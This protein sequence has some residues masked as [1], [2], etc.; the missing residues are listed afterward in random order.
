MAIFAKNCANLHKFC[1]KTKVSFLPLFSTQ[2]LHSYPAKMSIF[3]ASKNII[4]HFYRIKFLRE[5][6]K[7]FKKQSYRP[8]LH[9]YKKNEKWQ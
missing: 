6:D 5:N 9:L 7:M 8:A 1:I 2:S 3:I 4:F